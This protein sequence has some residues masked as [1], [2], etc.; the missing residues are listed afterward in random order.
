MLLRAAGFP[1]LH[2]RDPLRAAGPVTTRDGSGG[3]IRVAFGLFLFRIIVERVHALP[4]RTCIPSRA[5]RM[6]LL[7]LAAPPPDELCMGSRMRRA[8]PPSMSLPLLPP[9][10]NCVRRVSLRSLLCD[11]IFPLACRRCAASTHAVVGVARGRRAPVARS[12][13]VLARSSV[14]GVVL[15]RT[16]GFRCGSV[17]STLRR[18]R[19]GPRPLARFTAAMRN[20]ARCVECTRLVG[21]DE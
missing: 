8:P 13:S 3:M 12:V 16:R 1:L 15:R 7:P 18:L 10:D 20:A 6:P 9:H 2:R 11:A 14:H 4:Y 17:A 19:L 5:V 21:R